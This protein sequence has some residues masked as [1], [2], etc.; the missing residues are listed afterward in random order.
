MLRSSSLTSKSPSLLSPLCL[1]HCLGKGSTGTC[2]APA[3]WR[4]ASQ[5]LYSFFLFFFF[6]REVRCPVCAYKQYSSHLISCAW[7][8]TTIRLNRG[9]RRIVIVCRKGFCTRVV[10]IDW[11]NSVVEQCGGTV[12]WNSHTDGGGCWWKDGF[13]GSVTECVCV[14]VCYVGRWV[15]VVMDVWVCVCVVVASAVLAVL[16]GRDLYI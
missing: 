7:C 3:D 10:A 12:W 1:H 16:H 13:S 6:E 15:V 8:V 2:P 9:E 4:S 14:C 11:W 5:M